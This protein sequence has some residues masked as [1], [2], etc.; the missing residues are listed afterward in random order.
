MKSKLV[1]ATTWVMSDNSR[2]HSVLVTGLLVLGAA[3]SFAAT[4]TVLAD[5]PAPGGSR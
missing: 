5:G 4:G 1:L 2:M 3:F